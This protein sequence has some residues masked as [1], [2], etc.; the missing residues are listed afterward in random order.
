MQ[1]DLDISIDV[2][3]LPEQ[4]RAR[5]R[6]GNE[7]VAG[8]TNSTAVKVRNGRRS[9]VRTAEGARAQRRRSLRFIQRQS[10]H[11]Q[12]HLRVAADT[13]GRSHWQKQG[14]IN[15]LLHLEPVLAMF[16]Q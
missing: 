11:V 10:G 6:S 8:Q 7:T 2:F 13:P 5:A 12:A 1:I 3:S 15:S 4:W 14:V 16:N 9:P